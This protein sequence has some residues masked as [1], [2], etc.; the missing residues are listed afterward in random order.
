[1]T[2][3]FLQIVCS[4]TAGS[5]GGYVRNWSYFLLADALSVLQLKL[6]C[7]S[8]FY[9]FLYTCYDFKSKVI[10]GQKSSLAPNEV[11]L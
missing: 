4:D 10:H 3:L 7:N 5:F 9:R 8:L 6:M 2:R 11:T 1:M